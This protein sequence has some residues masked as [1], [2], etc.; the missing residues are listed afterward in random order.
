MEIQL[1]TDGQLYPQ[2]PAPP[3]PQPKPPPPPP[4]QPPPAEPSVPWEELL[5]GL[6][7]FVVFKSSEKPDL[8]LLL[9]LAYVLFD[10]RF[11]L[12]DLL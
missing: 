9:A 6:V 7:A 12:K 3:K 10:S 1:Q 8:P 11:H 4:P 5:L 2:R